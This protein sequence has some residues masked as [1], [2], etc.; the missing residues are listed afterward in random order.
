MW[1]FLCQF[2][3]NKSILLQI[4]YLSSVSWKV[5]PLYFFSSK[6]I[7][8]AQKEP[9]K[10]EKFWDFQVLGS[11]FVKLLMPILKRRVNSCP[12]FAFLFS[13]M[14]DYSS[15]LCLAQTIYSLLIRNPLKRKSLRLLSPQVKICQ[16][17][18]AYFKKASRFLPKFCIPLQ[19]HERYF[20]RTFLAQAIYALLKRNT[21]K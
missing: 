14:K 9:S 8:F 13:F 2:W 21:L 17:P 7:Y 5:I 15:V 16:I 19:F 12:N 3:N 4:L 18:Y 11:S 1:N 6:K 20:L 10:N